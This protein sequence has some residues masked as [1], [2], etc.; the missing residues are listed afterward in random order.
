MQILSICVRRIWN[1]LM[2]MFPTA[3]Q[4]CHAEITNSHT[5]CP[6]LNVQ[7]QRVFV[8]K[9]HCADY[10]IPPNVIIN[11]IMT[12]KVWESK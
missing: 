3:L 1:R 6:L 7:Q 12:S 5:L 11:I 10:D 8:T 2:T 4:E 9:K